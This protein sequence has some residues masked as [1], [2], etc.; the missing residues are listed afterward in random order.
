MTSVA[1]TVRLKS[2]EIG[3]CACPSLAG[4]S[5][6]RATDSA[7]ASEMAEGSA[8]ASGWCARSGAS[9]TCGR[10]GRYSRT[11]MAAMTATTAVKTKGKA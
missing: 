3:A 11:T 1:M 9:T 7:P 4:V 6:T 2:A 8:L 10:A 5:G